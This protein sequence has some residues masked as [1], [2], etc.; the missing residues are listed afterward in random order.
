MHRNVSSKVTNTQ[1]YFAYHSKFEPSYLKAKQ[2]INN[3]I[4]NGDSITHVKAKKELNERMDMNQSWILD[5]S[6]SGGGILIDGGIN[7]FSCILDMIGPVK[8]SSAD[9]YFPSSDPNEI[10]DIVDTKFVNEKG[11]TG[12][13]YYN[14]AYTGV[15]VCCFD[16]TL[17]SGTIVGWCREQIIVTYPDKTVQKYLV[18]VRE[19]GVDTV[20]VPM[21]KEYYVM[22]DA[23]VFF[24]KN[25]L[26]D[27]TWLYPVNAVFDTY[28]IAKQHVLYK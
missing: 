6:M 21:G 14:W 17:K 18:D 1:L 16:I 24:S 27:N 10:E 23:A 11:V 22:V 8:I 28:A 3:L 12:H 26:Y 7:I 2:I 19:K 5:K 15:G 25:E 13:I 20:Q 4:Q 9:L